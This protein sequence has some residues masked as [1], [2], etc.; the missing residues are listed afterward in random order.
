M[1]A[2]RG[3][4][5]NLKQRLSIIPKFKQKSSLSSIIITGSLILLIFSI[6]INIL[7]LSNYLHDI[8]DPPPPYP[9]KPCH[10]KIIEPHPPNSKQTDIN[11]AR[12]NADALI[13]E[14][15]INNDDKCHFNTSL[16]HRVYVY[17]LP[18]N[19]R[20]EPRMRWYEMF[21]KQSHANYNDTVNFNFGF[22]DKIQN[23][24]DPDFHSTHMH[25]L[26]IILNER[27]KK[28]DY[29]LTDNPDEATIFH[30]PF[31]FAQHFRYYHRSDHDNISGPH[32]KLYAL[33]LQTPAFKKY[34]KK[35]P[36][37]LVY[38]RIAYETGRLARM[39]SRFW[40]T[41]KNH[42]ITVKFYIQCPYISD[43]QKT[44]IICHAIIIRG[45]GDILACFN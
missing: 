22:G 19:M 43:H 24:D 30:I 39:D 40:K 29:Y 18:W 27:F 33:L 4:T 10:P 45:C 21:N 17:D 26:E 3:F 36:H 2:L 23:Y 44:S 1:S 35:K 41:S 20:E 6:S 14:Q 16:K 11:L 5:P 42:G 25:S 38:G 31:P 34:F 7:L 12:Q 28:A 9:I 37:F 32:N 13:T 8:P 15:T